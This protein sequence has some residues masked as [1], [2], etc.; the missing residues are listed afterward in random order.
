VD[1]Y[2]WKY[3]PQSIGA[4]IEQLSL[5]LNRVKPLVCLTFSQITTS[6]AKSDITHKMVWNKS[7]I[8][9]TTLLESH[10]HLVSCFSGLGYTQNFNLS[11]PRAN[12]STIILPMIDPGNDK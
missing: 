3:F 2:P 9:L 4:A 11:A 1:L 12:C 5:Y 6:V 8:S 10:L 7:V